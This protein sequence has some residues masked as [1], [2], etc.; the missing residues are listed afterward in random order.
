M[1]W[2]LILAP[3]AEAEADAEYEPAA[4]QHFAVYKISPINAEQSEMNVCS[5]ELDS[6]ENIMDLN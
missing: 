1:R 4:Q 2:H 3:E 6:N 5:A